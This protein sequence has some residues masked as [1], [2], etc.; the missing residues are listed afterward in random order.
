MNYR[1][2]DP[3][4]ITVERV[5]LSEGGHV[6]IRNEIGAVPSGICGISS[7]LGPGVH[8]GVT[9]SL[10]APVEDG[11]TVVAQA[12]TGTN[13][14]KRV[15]FESFGEHDDTLYRSGDDTII[16]ADQ[17]TITVEGSTATPTQEATPTAT[18][19]PM[20]TSTATP[21]P[22]TTATPT[23]TPTGTQAVSTARTGS[24][25]EPGTQTTGS[26]ERVD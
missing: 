4:T 15:E 2:T 26:P 12:Y 25:T 8:T 14:N 19:A 21:T 22:T 24:S 10:D 6:A 20:T 18:P 11:N 13:A 16:G 5:N 3:G 1:T 9:V 7:Y 23:A 17:A